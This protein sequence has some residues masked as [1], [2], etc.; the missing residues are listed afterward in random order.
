[1]APIQY[2]VERFKLMKSWGERLAF[3]LQ[4]KRLSQR[5]LATELK[6]SQASVSK[7]VK[8][9]NIDYSRLRQLAQYLRLNW[10]WL[11]Y[12]DEALASVVEERRGEKERLAYFASN[13]AAET[14]VAKEFHLAV[15]HQMQL[16]LWVF[17]V[18]SGDI[19]H[20][21]VLRQILGIPQ[22]EP[23]TR[24]SFRRRIV[25]DD[26]PVISRFI[27]DLLLENKQ[28]ASHRFR[29]KSNPAKWLYAVGVPIKGPN[30]DVGHLVGSVRFADN[31][32]IG[33]MFDMTT[34][35]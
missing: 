17:D 27:K 30:G 3:V 25:E 7:W 8:G 29:L 5:T 15:F 33:Q 22:D 26:M 11:R 9:G 34:A 20:S 23:T 2:Q 14:A 1:M 10:V 19:Y 21:P 32:I 24:D 16:G 12:G 13:T 28:V 4:S 6:V 31:E 35:G 18:K